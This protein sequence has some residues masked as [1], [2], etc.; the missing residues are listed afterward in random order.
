MYPIEQFLARTPRVSLLPAPTPLQ[1]M[2]R[3]LAGYGGGAYIKRDD[4]TGVGPGGNKVRSLEFLLGQALEE[5]CDLVVVAGPGQSNLCTLTAAACARLGLPC[6]SVHN[7]PPPEQPQGNL[8]LNRLLGVEEHFLGPVTSRERTDYVHRLCGD[9]RRQGRRPFVV[10]NGASTGRGALGYTAAVAE[11]REQCRSLGLPSLTIF[12]PA[13]NGGVAAGLIYGNALMGS[14]FEIV[15]MS[16]EHPRDRLEACLRD[17]IAQLEALTGLKAP[18]PLE[19]LCRITDQYRGAGWGEN[20]RESAGE[21]PAFVRQEG[22]FVENVY[23]SKVLV[24]MK[25]WVARGLTE[26]PVCFLHTG[27]FGSLFSQD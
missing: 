2:A 10:E 19:R 20:T 7:C 16:V 24:G 11:L 6:A 1:P 17:L 26:G 15:V 12:A 18:A 3:F 14:P 5:K 22:V 23:N 8:L 9:L 27:G 13:G 21:V 25:D 4:M